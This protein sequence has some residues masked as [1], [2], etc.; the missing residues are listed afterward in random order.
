MLSPVPLLIRSSLVPDTAAVSV[1]GV[2]SAIADVFTTPEDHL[3]QGSTMRRT[4][5]DNLVLVVNRPIIP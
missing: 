3:L 5:R 2:V 4:K 1:P